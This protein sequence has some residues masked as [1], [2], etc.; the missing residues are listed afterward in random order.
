MTRPKSVTVISWVLIVWALI[1]ALAGAF[2]LSSHEG[3]Q[4]LADTPVPLPVQYILLFS[5]PLILLISGLAIFQGRNWGRLLFLIW[6]IVNFGTRL[7][8]T[9][10]ALNAV[11]AVLIF[12]AILFFLF[13][14]EASA[15]FRSQT[16]ANP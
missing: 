6:G 14:S 8:V 16:T 11:F 7:F 1:G 10:L 12:L 5:G 9:P 13:R 3:R 2:L 15:Y 4:L